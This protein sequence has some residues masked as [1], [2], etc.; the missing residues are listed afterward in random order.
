MRESRQTDEQIY[1]RKPLASQQSSA[2]LEIWQNSASRAQT[3]IVCAE[4]WGLLIFDWFILSMRMQVI[5]DSP[6][7]R[8]GSAPMWGGK[9][10]EFRDWTI[11]N[12]ENEAIKAREIDV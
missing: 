9:K 7:A 6:F 11:G 2:M 10:G 4:G 5:L 3:C 12:I 1:R 8:P